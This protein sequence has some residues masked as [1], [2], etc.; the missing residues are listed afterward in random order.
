MLLNNII[1]YYVLKELIHPAGTS[2]ISDYFEISA[3]SDP[4][5]VYGI[6]VSKP[7][8]RSFLLKNS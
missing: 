4:I 7:R 8:Y 1:N 6:S 2:N 3:N 5:T